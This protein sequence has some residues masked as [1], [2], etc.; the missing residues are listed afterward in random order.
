MVVEPE[1]VS[2][3]RAAVVRDCRLE[4]LI[5]VQMAWQDS[6]TN[7]SFTEWLRQQIALLDGDE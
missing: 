2:Q 1:P 5:D 7:A 6:K 3:P 4:T